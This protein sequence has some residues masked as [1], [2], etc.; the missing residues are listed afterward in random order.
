MASNR[1]L[2]LEGFKARIRLCEQL[3]GAQYVVSIVM[4][5]PRD[6]DNYKATRIDGVEMEMETARGY[7]CRKLVGLSG[8]S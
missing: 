8:F 5:A 6:V 2:A 7:G 3:I 1:L 4:D